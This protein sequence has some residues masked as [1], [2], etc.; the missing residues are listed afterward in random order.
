MSAAVSLVQPC[1]QPCIDLHK[2]SSLEHQRHTKAYPCRRSQPAKTIQGT[3]LF[4]SSLPISQQP[5]GIQKLF[6]LH[7]TLQ[8][9]SSVSDKEQAGIPL[10]T[11]LAAAGCAVA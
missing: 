9:D 4:P 2:L 7:I 3:S 6:P 11:V 1:L 5:K 8:A 10:L